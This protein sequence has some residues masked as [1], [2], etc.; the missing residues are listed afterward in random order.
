MLTNPKNYRKVN[1]VCPLCKGDHVLHDE[2]RQETYCTECG[3]IIQDNSIL[4]ISAAIRQDLKE[5]KFIRDLWRK[6]RKK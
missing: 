1:T 6:K 2:H 5:V 4:L 3:Y